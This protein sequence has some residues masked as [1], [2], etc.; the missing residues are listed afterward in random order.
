[1]A[2][3]LNEKQESLLFTLNAVA[4]G[5]YADSSTVATYDGRSTD[6]VVKSLHRLRKRGFVAAKKRARGGY[7]SQNRYL[8]RLSARGARFVSNF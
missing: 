8:W 1:M 5:E 2:I 3:T 7:A 4:A 6:A